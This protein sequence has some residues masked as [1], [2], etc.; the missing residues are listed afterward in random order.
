M[1]AVLVRPHGR[2]HAVLL[3]VIGHGDRRGVPMVIRG[4][5]CYL[6]ASL[7][8]SIGGSQDWKARYQVDSRGEE[9]EGEKGK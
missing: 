5:P 3:L 7:P 1:A 4:N 6:V 9:A 8:I 2:G